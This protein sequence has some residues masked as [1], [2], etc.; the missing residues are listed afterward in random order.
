MASEPIVLRFH[1][2]KALTVKPSKTGFRLPE[3][4]RFF[5]RVMHDKGVLA[6]SQYINEEEA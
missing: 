1:K 4:N 5:E 2:K 3:A 6:N